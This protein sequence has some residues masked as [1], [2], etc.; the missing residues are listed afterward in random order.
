MLERRTSNKNSIEHEQG[1][2]RTQS[3][4]S[5]TKPEQSESKQQLALKEALLDIQIEDQAEPQPPTSQDDNLTDKQN[6]NISQS[7]G[8]EEK[9]SE[10]SS[11]ERTEQ[12]Q[13]QIDEEQKDCSQS[14]EGDIEHEDEEENQNEC[15]SD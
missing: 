8:F 14:K 1:D 9:D 3:R 6:D 4:L 5:N 12:N 2:S 10:S 11:S 7:D 13:T 15:Q